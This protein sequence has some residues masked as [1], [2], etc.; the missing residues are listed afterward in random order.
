MHRF[1]RLLN[2]RASADTGR[3]HVRANRRV[4]RASLISRDASQPISDASSTHSPARYVGA[5]LTP[6]QDARTCG[7]L[8]TQD[9][10][11]CECLNLAE[12]GHQS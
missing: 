12:L 9:A 8:L 11:T 7:C 2:V 1:T 3:Q 6:R 5:S 10:R 4:E